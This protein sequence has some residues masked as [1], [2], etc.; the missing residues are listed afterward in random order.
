PEPMQAVTKECLLLS[1]LCGLVVDTLL[2]VN[3][4]RDIDND[5][6]TGK[7]TL[8]VVMGRRKGQLFYLFLGLAATFSGLLLHLFGHFW[9]AWL[10]VVFFQPFHMA[11]F[12]EMW[13]IKQGAE[14]NR[15]LGITARNIFLYGLALSLGLLLPNP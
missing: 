12:V 11:A 3:N 14:L 10:P 2:V 4:V 5:R 13:N 7:R 8:I 1:V 6:R 9:A 15:I